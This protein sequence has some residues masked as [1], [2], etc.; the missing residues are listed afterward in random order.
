MRCF[1]ACRGKEKR[2][3]NR[4]NVKRGFRKNSCRE[5]PP[6]FQPQSLFRLTNLIALLCMYQHPLEQIAHVVHL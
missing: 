4:E 3:K 5:L 6:Q 1:D 2:K